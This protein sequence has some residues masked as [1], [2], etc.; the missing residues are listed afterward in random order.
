[1]VKCTIVISKYTR[2]RV[3]LFRHT[4]SLHPTIPK[5]HRVQIINIV[6]LP[7][8]KKPCWQKMI[9]KILQSWTTAYSAVKYAISMKLISNKY[10]AHMYVT[11]TASCGIWSR[12]NNSGKY[13]QILQLSVTTEQ[14]GYFN[15]VMEKL[16]NV[17][18]IIA[19]LQ[20]YRNTSL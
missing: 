12:D 10:C 1:M 7:C 16:L 2:A 15:W 20:T 19:M 9:F 5:F 3:T 8:G 6:F 4:F 17:K 14:Y 13:S 18:N 11:S